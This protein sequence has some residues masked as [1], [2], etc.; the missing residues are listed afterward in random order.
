MISV[1]RMV[2][3]AVSSTTLVLMTLP[4]SKVS[5]AGPLNVDSIA[6]RAV[7]YGL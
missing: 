3:G 7:S 2:R 1:S 6:S 5:K 4:R